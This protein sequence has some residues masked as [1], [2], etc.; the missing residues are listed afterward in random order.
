MKNIF[1]VY[2]NCCFYEII[3]LSYF[4]KFTGQETALCS[5]DGKEI[6]C[7]EGY[8]VNVDMEL[9]DVNIDDVKCLTITGG[10][11]SA[12]NNKA[13]HDFIKN[14]ADKG[15]IISAIC[16]GVDV[17]D[18]AGILNGIKSTHSEDIDVSNDKNII[19]ARANAYVD[20][21][22]EVA[23]KLDLFE[24]ENDLQETI[25][26]WKYHKRVQ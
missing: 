2:D 17:L 10:D 8:S 26:F 22:I 5:V 3:I 9:K 21:A 16:A 13:V 11:V 7:M 23:K 15:A 14:L 18:D 20:F 1:L 4:M 24:D 12:I 25:D 6:N 19:T